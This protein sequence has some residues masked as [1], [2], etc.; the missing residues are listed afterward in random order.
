MDI[1]LLEDHSCYE[2]SS[3]SDDSPLLPTVAVTSAEADSQRLSTVDVTSA[4]A[5]SPLVPTA[6][7]TSAEADS[8]LLPTVDVTSAEAGVHCPLDIDM[9]VGSSADTSNECGHTDVRTSMVEQ[10][11]IEILSEEGNVEVR[12]ARDKQSL[13]TLGCNPTLLVAIR[14]PWLQSDAQWWYWWW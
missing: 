7:V 9:L 4:E 14:R 2:I 5:D 12:R 11:R 1:S 3:G 8:P 13:I 10:L 6:D